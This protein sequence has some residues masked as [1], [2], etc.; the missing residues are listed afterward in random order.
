MEIY[1][2]NL[3]LDPQSIYESQNEFTEK[4]IYESYINGPFFESSRKENK[5]K[6]K[7]IVQ[8]IKPE[9]E[10]Y[11][12]DLDLKLCKAHRIDAII[13]NAINMI[14]GIAG[15]THSLNIPGFKGDIMAGVS[16]GF[17]G[18]GTSSLIMHIITLFTSRMYQILGVT[19]VP[20]QDIEKLMDKLNEK[21]S[22]DLGAGY[23]IIAC[24]CLPGVAGLFNSLP[25]WNFKNGTYL[26]LVDKKLQL[27]LKEDM[28]EA[29]EAVDE[30]KDNAAKD[31]AAD[32]KTDSTEPFI[33]NIF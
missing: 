12:I 5:E 4:A 16:G 26:L 7:K 19:F 15:L 33:I 29:E 13:R 11:F 32:A 1:E 23:R 18:G 31:N 28:K 30:L 9:L 10:K 22:E 21:F 2:L 6:I 17:I 14:I 3:S 8:D 20:Q 25:G 27:D 24:E